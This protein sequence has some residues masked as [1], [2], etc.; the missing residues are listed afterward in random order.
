MSDRDRDGLGDRM[1]RQYESRTRYMLPRRTWTVIRVDGKAFHTYTRG[2]E[3]P[4][5]QFLHAAMVA[6]AT[7]LCEEA[8]TCKRLSASPR[9]L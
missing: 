7:A 9:P 4:F 1:K 5:D 8:G 3:K 6:G 2:A